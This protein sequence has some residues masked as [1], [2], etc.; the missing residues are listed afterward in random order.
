M[1]TR[2][3]MTI[4]DWSGDGHEKTEDFLVESNKDIQDVREAHFRIRETTGIDIEKICSHYGEQTIPESTAEK[5]E[6]LG[7]TLKNGGRI[8]DSPEEMANL[9]IFLLQ[10]ADPELTL[11]LIPEQT[12]PML[13]FYGVD[14]K[15][16][17]IGAVGYGLL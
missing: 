5:L 16:R 12:Y 7:L 14:E 8:I 6:R 17:S 4:G 11:R 1:G 13:H 10:K 3:Y 2:F 15:G 9:W